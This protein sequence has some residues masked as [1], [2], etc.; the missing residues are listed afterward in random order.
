MKK[1]S[2]TKTVGLLIGY[3]AS[4]LYT[5]I[6]LGTMMSHNH[7]YKEAMEKSENPFISAEE[8]NMWERYASSEKQKRFSLEIFGPDIFSKSSPYDFVEN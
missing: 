3:S 4:I 8:S 7:N 1:R 2:I 6:V 5:G